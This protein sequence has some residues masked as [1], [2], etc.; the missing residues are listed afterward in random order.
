MSNSRRITAVLLAFALLILSNTALAED[1]SIRVV[2]ER[3]GDAF[4]VDSTFSLAVPVRTAWD[5]LTDFDH[6]VA[7]VSN[8]RSSKIIERR[9][10]T[11]LVQQEGKARFGIFSYSFS[12]E[13]EIRL[14]PMTRIRARQL[15][16]I[17]RRF[18]SELE[19][20]PTASGTQL[21]Y[22]AEVT[23]DSGIVRTF[24]GSFIEHEVEEQ[25]TALAAEMLRRKPP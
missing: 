3:R 14:E 23:P 25:F 11:L 4:I 12:S 6:M 15:S 18:T 10:D 8:L 9:G 5:V 7:I 13:R 2:I 1:P 17:A 19:M 20:V 16:G 21:R 22:H 24:G